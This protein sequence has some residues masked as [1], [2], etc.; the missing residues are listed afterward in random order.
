MLDLLL[1]VSLVAAPSAPVPPSLPADRTTLRPPETR[2]GDDVDDFFGT[3]VADP[4]R[5]LEDPDSPETQAWVKAQN[6]VTNAWLARVPERAAIKDRLTRLQDFERFTQGRTRGGRVFFLRNAGLQD[7]AVL[8]V[9]DRPRDAGRVLLDP[10]ALSKDGTV[11]LAEWAVSDDGALLSYALAEAG[12]D[13]LTWRVRDVATG[14]DRPDVVRWSK[15]SRASFTKDGSGFFYSRYDAP[16]EGGAALTAVNQGH[17]VYFHRLGTDQREDRLVF[18]QADQPEWYVGGEVTADGRWLVVT[19]SKG[20]NPETAVFLV[21]LAKPEWKAEPFLDAMDATYAVVGSRGDTFFVVTNKDAPR[22]RLVAIRRDAPA[23]D[24]WR[25]IVPE[26]PG[27]DVLATVAHV[28]GRFVAQWMRDAHD[29]L[30]VYAEDGARIA[31]VQL[32]ALGTVRDLD[33]QGPAEEPVVYVGFSGFTTP[34]ALL[35]VDA[36]SGAV[37]TWRAP[38]IAFDPRQFV[39]RQ[40]FFRSKDGTRVPMFLVHRKGI[41]LDGRNPTLLYGYGGFNVSLTPEFRVSVLVWLEMGGVYAMPNLRGG[42]EYGK[43]WY[44]A[45][46]LEH[47]QNVFDDFV[48]AAGWLVSN[49]YTSPARLAVNGGSNGGLLVGAVETQH[50]ELFGAAVTEVGVLDMLRFHRF[51]LGWGWKSDYGS[52]ET[53]EGFDVLHRYSPLHNVKKG[54]RYPPTLVVTADHDDRVVPAHSHKFTAALQAAQGGDAPILARIETRA[55]HGAGKPTSKVIEE[56]ADVYAFL[57][58]AL[59]MELP[60]GF[61]KGAGAAGGERKAAR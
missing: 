42:G 6:E 15:A 41:A 22:S 2:R 5:W 38:T 45:G 13:W 20:T 16:A 25:T 60:P 34:P 24:A 50:P 55:G 58:R 56:R 61:G 9:A 14:A 11:A 26:G 52:A 17:Q 18:R 3:K 33:L 37:E 40:V 53:K 30:E 12:S 39:T 43:A 47:K 44:D 19:A 46:R 4:Y 7:Q 51:T 35:R 54:T 36:R 8:H 27:R 28:G 10:N 57:L 29:A 21:D 23:I 31:K 1:A 49:G 48:A 32:P 59:R